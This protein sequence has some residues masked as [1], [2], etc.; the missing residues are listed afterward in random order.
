MCASLFVYYQGVI[1]L[2]YLKS[3][4]PTNIHASSANPLILAANEVCM[5]LSYSPSPP[6]IP[7]LWDLAYA[8][9]K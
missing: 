2:L 4:A 3:V 7:L 5:D 6:Y 9:A 8:H 1:H